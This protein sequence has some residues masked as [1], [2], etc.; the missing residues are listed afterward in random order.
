[1]AKGMQ[2]YQGYG[3]NTDDDI[4]A[5]LI[6]GLAGLPDTELAYD[7][8]LNGVPEGEMV[9]NVFVP[10]SW[11][12][13]A[14]GA[15]KAALGG[16]LLNNR[17]QKAQALAEQIANR[18]RSKNQSGSKNQSQSVSF[19]GMAPTGA[20]KPIGSENVNMVAQP[21]PVEMSVP[22]P[23]PLPGRTP[24]FP[25]MMPTGSRK[26]IGMEEDI[27]EVSMPYGGLT[28]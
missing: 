24:Q 1:M 20:R 2:G 11:T 27:F 10:P 12:Q 17:N 3:V 21:M 14:A 9:G 7:W 23:E 22:I 13:Y 6:A 25:G 8:M 4:Q 16:K 28:Y 19:P 26:P 5:E 18:L 15:A